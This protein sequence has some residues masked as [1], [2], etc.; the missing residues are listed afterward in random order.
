MTIYE[1]AFLSLVFVVVVAAYWL[2]RPK[3]IT[4]PP[5]CDDHDC[6]CDKDS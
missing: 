3:I 4:F 5:R 1:I 6:G 2:T